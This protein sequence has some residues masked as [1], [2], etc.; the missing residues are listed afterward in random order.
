[1]IKEAQVKHRENNV[2]TLNT[3]K[4]AV[5]GR[6]VKGVTLDSMEMKQT[7]IIQKYTKK[8]KKWY[9]KM[10]NRKYRR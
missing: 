2:T 1:M 4:V 6:V 10:T 3:H 7:A 5:R 8:M 9:M